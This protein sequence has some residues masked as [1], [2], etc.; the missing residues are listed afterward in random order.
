MTRLDALLT[1]LSIPGWI[2]YD[3]VT[4]GTR[5]W[6]EW[7]FIGPIPLRDPWFEDTVRRYRCS[8]NDAIPPLRTPIE[9]LDYRPPDMSL[10]LAGVIFHA[11]RC[12]S[13]LLVRMLANSPRL[14]VLAEPP[15]IESLINWSHSQGSD[16]WARLAPRLQAALSYLGRRRRSSEELLILKSESEHIIDRALFESIR[17]GV[18]WI[19]LF[20]EPEAILFSHSLRR[21]RQMVP[22]MLHPSRLGRNHEEITSMGLDRYCA[23]VLERTFAAAVEHL[24]AANGRAI[25]Y[26]R[27]P[28]YA[29]QGLNEHFSLGLSDPEID[30]MRECSRFDAKR[31][32]RKPYDGGSANH[33]PIPDELRAL[34]QEAAQDF[35]ERL[36]VLSSTFGC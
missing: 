24:E 32:G 12:G 30:A 15:V 6:L 28:A 11:S 10:P 2:P 19:F 14:S 9:T 1:E 7:R 17:P 16:D 33:G 36:E 3:L 22:S 26:R 13:T 34:G 23:L 8:V 5:F 31:I 4:K 35:Y 27:L 29:W 18:P 21:G 25:H 20:R